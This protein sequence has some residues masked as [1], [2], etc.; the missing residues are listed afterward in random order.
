MRRRLLAVAWFVGLFSAGVFAA[1]SIFSSWNGGGGGGGTPGGVTGNVQINAGG[2]NFGAYAGST[3]TNQV[4]TAL[5]AS[6]NGTCASIVNAM[7]TAGTIAASK[8]IG[9]DIAT[10]GT[11]TAG[12]WQ[13]TAVTADHGGTGNTAYTNGQLLIGNTATG[14][15]TKATLTAG[16]NIT[17]TNGNGSITI[18]SSGGGGGTTFQNCPYVSKTANYPLVAG[19]DCAV[20]AL[21]NAFTLTLPTAVSNSDIYVLMNWQ[22][23]NA[24]TVATTSAQTIN[25]A[26]TQTVLNGAIAVKS[27]GSNWRIIWTA[28]PA[29][30]DPGVDGVV[31]LW[32]NTNK[33]AKFTAGALAIASGKTAT[34]SNTLT[35]AGT[36]A[37]TMTFPSTSGTVN[38]ADSTSTL[39]NKTLDCVAGTG[40][41]CTFSFYPLWTAGVCQNVTASIGLSLPSSNAPTAHCVTGSNTNFGVAQFTATTQNLQGYVQLPNDWVASQTMTY[42]LSYLGETTSSGNVV[43]TL[44]TACVAAGSGV[45][46]SFTS[47]TI[48]DAATTANLLNVANGNLSMPTCGARNIMFWK[49]TLTTQPTT[50]G[51]QD[52]VTL[53]LGMTRK[54]Q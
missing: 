14:L 31:W 51:N 9:T 44:G 48:T 4:L 6:G 45:D 3:C 33:T 50:P 29:V 42:E 25:G 34:F 43:W 49:L 23:A 10:V 47:T 52:L 46:P 22:T 1:N 41:H 27:D 16:S 37:T 12:V 53:S 20:E 11:I 30:T 7:I 32:D 5:D 15:L 2:G 8:L 54:P 40:N 38:T 35:L 24:L 17:I 39:T 18:A 19:T 13:G 36:D 21:T 28:G 26:S